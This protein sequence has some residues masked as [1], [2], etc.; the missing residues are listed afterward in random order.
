MTIQI[1]SLLTKFENVDNRETE[2]AF[3]QTRIAPET[4]LNVVYKP[5]QAE[6]LFSVAAKLK[7]PDKFTELL[8][9]QNGAVL[10]S[11]AF[12]VYG[13]VP[14]G[15]LLNRNDP[16]SLPPYNIEDEN[17]DWPPDDPERLLVIGGYGFDGSSA[18]IDRTT[19]QIYLFQRGEQTLVSS[20]SAS[21]PSPGEWITSEVARL[22][23]LF[24]RRGKRMV[25]QSETPPSTGRVS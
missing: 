6:T 18:C 2:T 9:Q 8:A 5:A 19:S 3:F 11:G 4:Y 24:D 20:P 22:S 17:R 23:F 25:D 15:T 14:P 21:W 13:V 16:L 12:S 10:F 7:F 1:L